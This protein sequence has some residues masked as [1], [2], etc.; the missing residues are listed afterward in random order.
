MNILDTPGPFNFQILQNN[1]QHGS[2]QTPWT[3]ARNF[4]FTLDLATKL[5]SCFSMSPDH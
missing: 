3:I 2:L 5:V 4:A 1:L